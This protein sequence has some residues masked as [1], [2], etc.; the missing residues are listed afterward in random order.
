MSPVPSDAS[1]VR[2][3]QSQAP[4][5]AAGLAGVPAGA[6]LE[7]ALGLRDIHPPAEPAFWPPAP[8][9]WVLLA[10]LAAGMAAATTRAWRAYRARARR[11]RILAELGRISGR[12]QGPAL[13]AAV[14]ALLK[15]V[16]L[17]RFPGGQVA[18]LT[19][20]AWLDFLDRNGGAGRFAAGVGRVLAEGPYAPAMD[21]DPQALLDLAR[22]W[23]RKN[24]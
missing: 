14:S 22:D 19:G 9:W 23:V 21:V 24:T 16:A 7:Q 1:Q 2:P 17:A 6:S 11:R 4:D 12:A 13:A 10:L 15:R 20:Q 18:P 5:P 3:G 8:G